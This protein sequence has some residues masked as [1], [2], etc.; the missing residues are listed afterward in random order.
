MQILSFLNKR[1]LSSK[2]NKIYHG[3]MKAKYKMI[4]VAKK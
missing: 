1:K 3:M 4:K 2:N